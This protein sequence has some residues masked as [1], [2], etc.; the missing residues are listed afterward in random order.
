MAFCPC[1]C[2]LNQQARFNFL[3]FLQLYV[4]SQYK[5]LVS[6]LGKFPTTIHMH[7]QLLWSRTNKFLMLLFYL[8]NQETANFSTENNIHVHDL[9]TFQQIT[10]LPKARGA[11]LFACDL[12][13]SSSP[14]MEIGINLK[15]IGLDYRKSICLTRQHSLNWFVQPHPYQALS[16]LQPV[17]ASLPMKHILNCCHCGRSCLSVYQIFFV[18]TLQSV[19]ECT[20]KYVWKALK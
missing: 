20:R 11:T 3:L 5:I 18:F 9:L 14:V 17:C 19:L 15:K 2:H 7:N 16:A 10:V 12:Q 6:L 4:V 8:F 13:V 1:E